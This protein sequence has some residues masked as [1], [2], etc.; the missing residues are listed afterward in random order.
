LNNGP[1]CEALSP[2]GIELGDPRVFSQ[3]KLRYVTGLLPRTA[4]TFEG[5]LGFVGGVHPLVPLI[6][7]DKSNIEAEGLNSNFRL[8]LELLF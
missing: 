2:Q 7:D 4:V 1:G 6:Y 8:G 5:N 3:A